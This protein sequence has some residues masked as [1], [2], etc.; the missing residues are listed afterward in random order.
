MR[1]ALLVICLVA[2]VPVVAKDAHTKVSPGTPS[3]SSSTASGA[4]KPAR[5]ASPEDCDLDD[6]LRCAV[7][8]QG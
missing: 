8:C 3:V 4:T 7:G 5:F 2:A 1:F 6:L